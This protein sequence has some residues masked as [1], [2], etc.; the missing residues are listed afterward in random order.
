[1]LANKILTKANDHDGVILL[2][3]ADSSGIVAVTRM[4][5]SAREGSSNCV[6]IFCSQINLSTSLKYFILLYDKT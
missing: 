4:D 2:G 1:M 3:R 6:K 5:E